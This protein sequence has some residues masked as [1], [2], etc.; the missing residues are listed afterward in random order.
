MPQLVPDPAFSGLNTWARYFTSQG[1]SF[2]LYKMEPMRM[3]LRICEID[4]SRC[5]EYSQHIVKCSRKVHWSLTASGE[6]TVHLKVSYIQPLLTSDSTFS[7]TK[8]KLWMRNKIKIGHQPP[9]RDQHCLPSTLFQGP[10]S[11]PHPRHPTLALYE[12]QLIY[13]HVQPCE[14]ASRSPF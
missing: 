8:G 14:V 7:H 4:N 10:K 11:L 5:L 3:A 6:W 9:P 13:C 2:F 12:Q 1:L